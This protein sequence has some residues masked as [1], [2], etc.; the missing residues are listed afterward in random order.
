MR[1]I[2]CRVTGCVIVYALVRAAWAGP[3][4]KL[5]M[6]GYWRVQGIQ[7]FN[8]YD[9]DHVPTGTAPVEPAQHAAYLMQ[10]LRLEPKLSFEKLVTLRMQADVFD[11]A[12]WGDNEQATY[13]VPLFAEQPT[14]TNFLGQPVNSIQFKR[15]WLEL[16]IPVGL[17]RIG[18]QPSN[19]GLGILSNAGDGFDDDFGENHFGSTFDRIAFATK[20]ISI[21]KTIKG[22]PNV[23]SNFIIA[24][25]YDMLSEEP[26]VVDRPPLATRGFDCT[27]LD[28]VQ[29]YTKFFNERPFGSSNWLSHNSNDVQ[30][31][32]L[33]A[34]YNNEKWHPWSV[35]DQLKFGT[36]IVFRVQNKSFTVPLRP[37]NPNTGFPGDVD[38]GAF[39]GIYD[40]YYKLRWGPWYSEAE[41]YYI[42]GRASGV[43]PLG[44][45]EKDAGIIGAVWR[46][47]WMTDQFDAIFEWGYSSG[48][49]NI[50]DGF[51]T[52]RPLHPDYNVGLILY[53]E[54]MRQRSYVVYSRFFANALQS[55]GGVI[56]SYYLFP[57]VRWRPFPGLEGV[58]GVLAAWRDQAD[59]A[60]FD[61]ARDSFMGF[62]TDAGIKYSW[63]EDHLNFKLEGG[64]LFFGDA[65]GEY[66]SSVAS[67]LQARMAFLF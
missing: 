26:C 20:P 46:G 45:Y 65:L 21:Y 37:P 29:R 42:R 1:N 57:R 62:E 17:L 4:I 3:D 33:V 9:L 24:Y 12:V 51:F 18:R 59:N 34:Y 54:V 5:E 7:L 35:N 63:A 11:D 28:P 66:N 31:H 22:A 60:L 2:L 23:D 48:D 64:L 53:E 38:N 41:G 55:L 61:P 16:N 39:A 67:S 52:Q 44:N 56:D 19:W 25:A 32:I 8:Q 6:G 58:L 40:G 30:E 50:G 27:F 36:Y 14:S 49:G 15:A 47:G 13:G 43:L 10:R